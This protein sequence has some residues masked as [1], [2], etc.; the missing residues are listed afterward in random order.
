MTPAPV[1]PLTHGWCVDCVARGTQRRAAE[2]DVRCAAHGGRVVLDLPLTARCSHPA[3]KRTETGECEKC[4]ARRLPGRAR[5]GRVA[6]QALELAGELAG[7]WDG[8]GY[9][10]PGRRRLRSVP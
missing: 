4:G 9:K 6:S 8:L 2:G 1:T 10:R 5:E 3:E 7:R